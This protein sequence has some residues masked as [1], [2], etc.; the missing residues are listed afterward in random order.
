MAA[1][2]A[3]RAFGATGLTTSIVGFGAMQIGDPQ[4]AETDAAGLLNGVLDAGI[5]LIDTARSYG[6]AEE[7]IGRHLERRRGEYVL[8]TKV[9][10]GVDGVRDWTYKCVAL[11]IDRARDRLRTDVID[12]VH[13]HSCGLEELRH[14]VLDALAAAREQGKIRVAAYSG[15]NEPLAAALQSGLV[16]AIQLS[17]NLCDQA[18]MPVARRA[19][20]LGLGVLIKR[21]LLGLPWR[22]STAPEDP[23]HAEYFRRFA[24]LRESFACDDWQMLALRFAAFAPGV[25]CCIVGG[26]NLEHIRSNLA[27]AARGPLSCGELAAV[28]AAYGRADDGWR[29][30]V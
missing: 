27:T 5:T 29:G 10:Y 26:T 8:S 25:A 30:I 28:A 24:R 3:S 12:I 9:G 21:S 17:I 22:C 14:G 7:R 2:L 20:D 15:D 6:V 18:G 23:P 4:I 19:A 1:S 11:G 13:L 16:Q